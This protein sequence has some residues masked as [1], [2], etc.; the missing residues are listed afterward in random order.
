MC[1]AGLMIL[2][3]LLSTVLV[4]FIYMT[5][6]YLVALIIK[7]ND[8]ADVAWG[9][10][11]IVV[12][13]FLN[14]YYGSNLYSRVILGLTTM[15]GLRLAAHIYIRNKGK[16]EDFRYKKWRE[17]WG[18]W[19]YIRTYLQVFLLQ[20]F[21]MLLISFPA[22]VSVVTTYVD[23]QVYR[24][25]GVVVWFIGFYFESLGD[26]Q[27]SQFLKDPKNKGKIM[28]E[29]VWRYTRHPNYFGEVTQWWG[30]FLVGLSV[31]NGLISIIGPLTITFLI[32]KVS[33]IPMLE[34]KYK[35][36]PEFQ[37]YKKRTNAFFPWFP[38]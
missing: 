36:N 2:N 24:S 32:L 22:M 18:K 17:D 13:V 35:D 5:F 6:W 31:P 34:E 4:I 16:S 30:I 21:F 38:K 10:G 3:V 26:Y 23:F 20:G 19:F 7:R 29:G 9:V 12:A 33:G 14:I 1:Y 27:L 8:I 37:E 15:W 11:F 25:L 28:M